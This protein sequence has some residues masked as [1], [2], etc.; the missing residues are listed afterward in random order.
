MYNRE[1][2]N[3]SIKGQGYGARDFG[4]STND[5]DLDLSLTLMQP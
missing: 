3:Q 1:I 5:C 2:S 4:V